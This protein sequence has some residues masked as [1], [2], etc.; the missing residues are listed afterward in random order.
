[1]TRADKISIF[2]FGLIVVADRLTKFWALQTCI[3]P[4]RYTDYF[5][6]ELVFNRGISWS[7]LSFT[8]SCYFG[9]VTALVTGI[10]VALAVYTWHQWRSG[11]AI[12]GELMVLAGSCANLYDRFVYG[13]VIDFIML[14]YKSFTWPLFNIADVAIVCGVLWMLVHLMRQPSI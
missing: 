1:V 4:Q 6:C 14:S 5:S 7:L 9:C 2:F 3:F 12:I 13:G 8:D 11:F 10:T